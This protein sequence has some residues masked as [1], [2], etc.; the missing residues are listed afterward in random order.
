[1]QV[2]FRSFSKRVM[3]SI[4]KD[5]DLLS[6][7]RVGKNKEVSILVHVKPNSKKTGVEWLEDKL[8][9]KLSSPPVDNKANKEVCEVMSDLVHIPKGQISVIRGGKSR[10]KEIQVLGITQDGMLSRIKEALEMD[11]VVCS[12]PDLLVDRMGV[13]SNKHKLQTRFDTRNGE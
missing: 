7:I 10:E 8:Y 5:A 2:L 1:M 12:K 6:T 13:V 3:S 9:L 4:P 11:L